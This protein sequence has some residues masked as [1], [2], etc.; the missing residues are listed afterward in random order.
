[1]QRV[2]AWI[3]GCFQIECLNCGNEIVTH[4]FGEL[5]DLCKESLLKIVPPPTEK[6]ADSHRLEPGRRKVFSLYP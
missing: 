4:K 1:M 2:C 5:S 6:S 3:L